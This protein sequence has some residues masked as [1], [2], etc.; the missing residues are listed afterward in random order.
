V[1]LLYDTECNLN[2]GDFTSATEEETV[3]SNK[4]VMLV[5]FCIP[6]Y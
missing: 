5:Y 6:W 2:E 4:K 3:E 1:D